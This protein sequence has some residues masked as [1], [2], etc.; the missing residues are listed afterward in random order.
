MK[1]VDA[2]VVGNKNCNSEKMRTNEEGCVKTLFYFASV[3]RRIFIPQVE[4]NRKNWRM[5]I[6]LRSVAAVTTL[7]GGITLINLCMHF[8]FPQPLVEHSYQSYIT[9][10]EEKLTVC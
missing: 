1:W 3:V 6:N 4:K 7:G 10:L 5:D 8:D 2:R 9:F